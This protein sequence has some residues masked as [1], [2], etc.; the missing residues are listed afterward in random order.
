MFYI[1]G[2]NHRVQGKQ[3]ETAD[4]EDQV[5]FRKCLVEIID[6]VKPAVAAEEYSQYALSQL[7]K[8]NG[9]EH[10][11]LA[12]DVAESVKVAHRFCDPEPE[13][14]KKMGYLEGTAIARQI[15]MRDTKNLSNAEINDLAFAIEVARFWP[16]RENFWLSQL[17]DVKHQDLVFVCDEAHIDSFI[18]LLGRS[19]I[20][21]RIVERHIGVTQRDDEWWNRVLTYLT[22]HPELRDKPLKDLI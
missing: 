1:V 21:A 7:G 6:K 13:V 11:A 5:K 9:A 3:K 19:H 17:D 2:V 15:F 12:K 14:R 4:T 22:L 18:K 20:G 8:D 10:E 16:V